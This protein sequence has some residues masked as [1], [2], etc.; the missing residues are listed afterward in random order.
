MIIDRLSNASTY[1]GLTPRLERALRFLELLDAAQAPVGRREIAG[2]QV[3]ALIQEYESKPLSQG[4]WEAHRKYADIQYV[5]AG[6]EQ[7]GYAHVDALRQGEYDAERDFLPLEG[8]G[9]LLRL[10]AG[11]FAILM[12]QDAHMP[13]MAVDQPAPVKKV[14]VK[15]RI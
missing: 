1:Y 10:P 8:E 13:G 15:V 7:L 11:C 12:P 2:E 4:A 14:V 9:Q 5:A 6:V 3:F